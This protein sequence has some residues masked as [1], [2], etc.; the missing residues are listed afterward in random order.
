MKKF[1]TPKVVVLLCYV[2]SVLFTLAAFTFFVLKVEYY[3]WILA[4]LGVNACLTRADLVVL[5][6]KFKQIN[7]SFNEVDLGLLKQQV[8]EIKQKNPK[9]RR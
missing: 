8:Q 4:L 2:M 1:F 7:N 9:L 3:Y 5:K 6:E